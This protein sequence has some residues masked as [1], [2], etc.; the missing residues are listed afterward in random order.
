MSDIKP[1]YYQRSGQDLIDHFDTGVLSSAQFTGFMVG[2]IIKYVVR[3]Q[4]KNGLE[5]LLKARTYLDRLIQVEKGKQN[6][7]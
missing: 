6:E 7:N 3:Y 2:N 4:G 1:E 5:D